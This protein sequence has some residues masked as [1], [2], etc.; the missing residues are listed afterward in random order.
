M[1][2][3]SQALASQ[4]FVD[5]QQKLPIHKHPPCT[6]TSSFKDGACDQAQ[7]NHPSGVEIDEDGSVVVA[8]TDNHR[9]RRINGNPTPE[10]FTFI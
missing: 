1:F 9:I 10:F 3:P 2:A 7:F 6:D 8:D 4:V 5:F